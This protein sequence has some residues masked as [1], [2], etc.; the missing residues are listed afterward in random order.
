MI[1]KNK[2]VSWYFKTSII[3]ILTF[4]VLAFLI[5]YQYYEFN[6]LVDNFDTSKIESIIEKMNCEVKYK[7]FYYKGFCIDNDNIWTFL[8]QQYNNSMGQTCKV[9]VDELNN[10]EDYLKIA[11]DQLNSCRNK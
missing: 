2:Y 8:S 11:L 3:F 7:E 4:I 10:Y 5:K 9:Y 6:E 1:S